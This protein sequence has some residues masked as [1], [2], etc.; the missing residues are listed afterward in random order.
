RQADALNA[1]GMSRAAVAAQP[2]L[3]R[4]AKP[5]DFHKRLQWD[6]AISCEKGLL[7]RSRGLEPPRVAPLAP[8]ASASTNSATTAEG[9]NASRRPRVEGARCNK[10]TLGEQGPR[11]P[12]R[13]GGAPPNR[14]IS[15]SYRASPSSS[16]I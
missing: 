1:R 15:A 13:V 8:Q 10:S 2:W 16:A 7:V 11:P 9:M 3:A 6:A 4:L 5:R 12:G 14:P